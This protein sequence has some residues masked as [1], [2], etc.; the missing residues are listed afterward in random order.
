MPS[1]LIFI[2]ARGNFWN[3]NTII[4]MQW[5]FKLLNDI[6][7]IVLNILNQKNSMHLV[8]LIL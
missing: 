5:V 6:N 8:D 1:G 3:E 7:Q 4:I 2:I